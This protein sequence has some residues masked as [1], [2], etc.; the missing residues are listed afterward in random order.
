MIPKEKQDRG[1]TQCKPL[2]GITPV[3]I[4]FDVNSWPIATELGLGWVGL[5]HDGLVLP[6]EIANTYYYLAHQHRSAWTFE[7]DLRSHSDL[8]WWNHQSQ[9]NDV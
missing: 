7:L 4:H 6:S 5:E 3:G 9:V 2:K 8:A 1:D